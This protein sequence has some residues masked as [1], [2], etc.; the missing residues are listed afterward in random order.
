MAALPNLVEF[1]HAG[2]ALANLA[3]GRRLFAVLDACDCPPVQAKTGQLGE[4]KAPCLFKGMA[5]E[6]YA[7]VAPYLVQVD[8]PMLAWI[9]E[10]LK[11]EPWGV[12]AAASSQTSL[13][14]LERHFRRFLM[15]KS[16]GGKAWSFRFYDPRVLRTYLPT[17]E[18]EELRIVYGPLE[19]YGLPGDDGA[20]VLARPKIPLPSAPISTP[21]GWTLPLRQPQVDAFRGM[22]ERDFVRRVAAFVRENVSE[23][24][25]SLDEAALRERIEAGLAKA[26]G[27]G[28]K[29]E[30]ALAAFVALQL[31]FSPDFDGYPP[32]KKVLADP[33]IPPV[34]RLDEL[35]ARSTDEDWALAAK[36]RA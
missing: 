13:A 35:I 15:V 4:A 36:R 24:T 22:A 27:Y 8:A 20:V 9:G 14:D 31:E 25:E 7:E 30:A 11:G 12:F 5:R 26:R 19:A 3:A 34:A 2:D 16:P 18:K 32:F 6:Q 17:C 28:L 23:A 21:L 1:S 10:A 29:K 33:S